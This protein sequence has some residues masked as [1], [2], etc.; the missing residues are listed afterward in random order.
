MVEG[1]QRWGVSDSL[2]SQQ[3]NWISIRAGEDD[4]PVGSEK[5]TG[6]GES[7]CLNQLLLAQTRAPEKIF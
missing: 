1:G 6:K 2:T 7:G 3:T 5:S 4:K